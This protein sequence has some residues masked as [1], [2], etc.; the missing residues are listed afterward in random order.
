[1]SH[2]HRVKE[3]WVLSNPL[4]SEIARGSIDGMSEFSGF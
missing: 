4:S 1:M 2:T 3:N